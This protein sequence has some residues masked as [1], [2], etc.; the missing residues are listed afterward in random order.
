MSFH[1]ESDCICSGDIVT[2]QCTV[3]SGLATV[4]EGTA[5]E[6][7]AS[8]SNE[9]TSAHGNFGKPASDRECSNGR[10]VGRGLSVDN[11]C[12]TSQ[13][14]VTFEPGLQNRTVVCSVDDG[15]QSNEVGRDVLCASTGKSTTY[16]YK[17]F[18][19]KN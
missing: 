13:L 11:G 7:C 14:N 12:Y 3:C 16:E 8:N 2:Y 4:W 15:T 10:I 6:N 1:R 19:D 18:L 17:P 5:I 9:I